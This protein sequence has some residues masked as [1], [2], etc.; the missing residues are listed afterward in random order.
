MTLLDRT[1]AHPLSRGLG[2][3]LSIPGLGVLA[4]GFV[5]AAALLPV[6]QSSNA[7]ATGHQI[8]LLEAQRADLQA[9]IY[10]TQAEVATLG[11]TDRVERAARE[12]LGM[13]PADRWLYVTVNQPAPVAGVP[14]RYLNNEEEQDEQATATRPWWKAI[15]AKLP[16]P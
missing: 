13:V 3:R 8:R 5:A 4:A 14:A 11:A 15:V 10:T 16:V 7:T 12:R 2:R 1:T 9:R 6:A